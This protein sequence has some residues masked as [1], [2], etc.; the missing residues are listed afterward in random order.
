M[1]SYSV[2]VSTGP[3]EIQ[4]WD[5][6]CQPIF[7]IRHD[8]ALWF[9]REMLRAVREEAINGAETYCKC[10]EDAIGSKNIEL[11][12]YHVKQLRYF[13]KAKTRDPRLDCRVACMVADQELAHD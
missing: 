8:R 7:E 4:V 6:D 12:H 5:G 2:C 13:V 9:I 11:V 1:S 3:N 10:V